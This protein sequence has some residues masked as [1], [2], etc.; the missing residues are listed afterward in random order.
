MSGL[1]LFV[2]NNSLATTEWKSFAL[3]T[4][5]RGEFASIV[6]RPLAAHDLTFPQISSPNKTRNSSNYFT[7]VEIQKI[8]TESS[9]INNGRN[10]RTYA[11]VVRERKQMSLSNT[12]HLMNIENKENSKGNLSIPNTHKS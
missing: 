8:V 6:V 2:I 11:D 7:I 1:A 5:R 12:T 10:G 4:L 9:I 3:F